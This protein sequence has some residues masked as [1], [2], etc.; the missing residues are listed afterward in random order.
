M[1]YQ[2]QTADA[3]T[4]IPADAVWADAAASS[5][6]LFYSVSVET[7]SADAAMATTMTAAVVSAEIPV[8]P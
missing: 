3:V 4:T 2:L 8:K 7:A 1:T 6:L 5:G